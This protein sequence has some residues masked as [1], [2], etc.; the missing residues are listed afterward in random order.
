MSA[1]PSV[2][3]GGSLP[4][5]AAP[6]TSLADAI[7][8]LQA[9]VQQL[10]Q[11]VAQLAPAT[12]VQGA[13]AGADQVTG[14][15]AAPT[16]GCGM[17]GCGGMDGSVGAVAGADAVGEGAD[18]GIKAHGAHATK[19]KAHHK[20]H[21]KA[22][23]GHAKPATHAPTSGSPTFSGAD[24]VGSEA[25]IS[26]PKKNPN[27]VA[28]AIAW[29][30][31]EAASGSSKW[32]DLCLSFVAHAYGW[33]ASGTATALKQWNELPS[34]MQ[35][36]GDTS[37]PPGAL[38]YWKHPGSSSGDAGHVA[39]YLGNG[40]IASNDI[41]RDGHISIVDVGDI[42]RKWGQQYLGWAPPYFKNA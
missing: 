27:S 26:V 39:I 23:A 1:L 30:K 19:Q 7:T 12:A 24:P 18:A 2:S 25:D 8:Q 11:L 21:H 5:T 16:G 22:A 42:Q 6:P 10:S 20:A 9:A 14:G 28:E 31:R 29:A 15:G 40:K 37:P 33:P 17:A 38:L 34:S 4:T 13:Q 35:H 41:V 32:H 36:K 3:G